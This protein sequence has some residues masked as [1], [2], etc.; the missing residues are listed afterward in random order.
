[1]VDI[2]GVTTIHTQSIIIH[3]ISRIIPTTTEEA[4]TTT[5]I[6]RNQSLECLISLIINK[7][8]FF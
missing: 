6:I 4:T 8:T 1:M 7:Y 3:L 2:K 5:A